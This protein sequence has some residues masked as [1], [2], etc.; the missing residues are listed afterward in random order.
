MKH[1]KMYIKIT[2]VMGEKRINLAYLILGKEVVVDSVFSDNVQYQIQE[3][4]NILLIR[5][6]E[7][8]LLKGTLTGRELST[9]IGRKVI[10]TPLDTNVNVVKMDKLAHVME[11]TL[12]KPR[13]FALQILQ[14]YLT[15]EGHV[16]NFLL[17]IWIKE[18]CVR[19]SG[20]LT[21]SKLLGISQTEVVISLDELDNTDNLEDGR[22]SNV[23]LRYHLTANGELMS[24]KAVAPQYKR[25]KNREF[26]FLTMK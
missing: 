23:L 24:F 5:N 2:D 22:L 18:P 21:C 16:R 14:C 1:F 4:L 26:T 11:V 20:G 8:L 13:V 9:F 6:E 7:K 25:L 19:K 3:P 12:R 15:K 17:F 10:T